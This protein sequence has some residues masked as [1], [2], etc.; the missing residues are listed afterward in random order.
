MGIFL[1]FFVLPI[2][3]AVLI[4]QYL[5]VFF[6]FDSFKTKNDLLNNLIPFN[7]FIMLFNKKIK[8]IKD[9]YKKINS[10]DNSEKG[11]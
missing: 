4:S 7:P 2:A 3:L 8:S 11:H 10:L 5:V 1:I 9:H 6:D